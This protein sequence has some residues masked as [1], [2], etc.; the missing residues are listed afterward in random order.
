M[1]RN[2]IIVSCLL[3]AYM[4]LVLH[5]II[6]HHHHF[7]AADGP[8][9]FHHGF[10]AH[11]QDHVSGDPHHDADSHGH[12]AHFVHSPEFGIAMLQPTANWIE[13]NVQKAFPALSEPFQLVS[14]YNR[15]ECRISWVTESPPPYNFSLSSSFSLRGPPAATIA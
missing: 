8:L 4:L 13:V 1:R 6:P 9:H 7:S 14:K 3:P 5:A 11:H 12:T 10:N 2:K 15:T